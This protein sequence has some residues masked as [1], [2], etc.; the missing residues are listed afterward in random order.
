MQTRWCC[1]GAEI[2]ASFHFSFSE[3]AEKMCQ[4]Q[5]RCKTNPN[6]FCF[7]SI[8]GVGNPSSGAGWLAGSV[9]LL[10]LGDEEQVLALPMGFAWF[11][12]ASEARPRGGSNAVL[13]P[14]S[15][16]AQMGGADGCLLPLPSGPSVGAAMLPPVTPQQ[17]LAA[18]RGAGNR[19]CSDI[20]GKQ[21]EKQ[22]LQ[23]NRVQKVCLSGAGV[24]LRSATGACNQV[25]K[26]G[27][28]PAVQP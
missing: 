17:V 25:C 14:R 28:Q 2:T 3:A 7:P 5:L 8:F 12:S 1:S 13:P 10:S 11:P 24:A 9:F 15:L 22:N 23:E 4:W 18:L 19:H 20:G 26:P 6:P 27:M 16:A 21:D